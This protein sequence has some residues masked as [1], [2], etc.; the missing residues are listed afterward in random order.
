MNYITSCPECKTQFLLNTEH[1]K[2]H[3]G[4]VQCGNCEHVFNA[5]NRVTE[6]SDDIHSTEEYQASLENSGQTTE[7][8]ESYSDTLPVEEIE[9]TENPR[10]IGEFHAEPSETRYAADTTR[11]SSFEDFADEPKFSR[12]KSKLSIWLSLFCLLLILIAGLQSVYF[13][14][15]KI[16]AE[17]PQFKPLLVQTCAYL[18]CQISLP[19]DLNLLV[20]DDSDMQENDNYQG[21]INFSSVLMNNASFAQTYPNIELTLTNADDQP[22]LRK[23]IKP[24]EYLHN[25]PDLKAGI[26]AHEEIHIK[27]AIHASN[28]PVAGYRVLLVY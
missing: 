8:A 7:E 4:K 11:P 10:Y 15:T 18:N 5:K 14:R 13:M 25:K 12:G 17:Y 16:A 2:A 21:V 19:K 9:I 24:A 28:L 20:I 3:R 23:L 27:L 6:V 1:L 22:V 26:D